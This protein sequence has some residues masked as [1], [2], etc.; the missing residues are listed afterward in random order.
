[1][2][3]REH[4]LWIAD[5]LRSEIRAERELFSWITGRCPGKLRARLWEACLRQAEKWR[6]GSIRI[7]ALE[8]SPCEVA[9]STEN[10]RERSPFIPQCPAVL[11][12][13]GEI[14]LPSPRIAVFNSRKPRTVR[15]DAE[16]LQ[17]LRYLLDALGKGKAV[18]STSTGTLTYDMVG[19]HAVSSGRLPVL[20]TPSSVLEPD[21]AVQNLY[22]DA[23]SAFPALSCMIET[24]SC[25]KG[26]R[27]QCRDRILAAFAHV[28]CVL[29][30]RRGGNLE[31]VL[32]NLHRASPRRLIVFQPGEKSPGNAG[33]HALVEEF[34][35]YAHVFSLR[36]PDASV[37]REASPRAERSSSHPKS[38]QPDPRL[39]LYHYTRSCPGPWPG[40]SYEQYLMKLLQGDP[41]AGHSALDTLARILREGRLRAASGMVRG[42]DA[43]VSWTSRTPS[44]IAALRKW[45]PALV[46]W[47]VEPCGVAV[48]RDVLRALGA[49]PAVYGRDDHFSKLPETER[50]R[51]QIGITR[52]AEWRHEREWRL[53]GD[54]SLDTAGAGNCFVFVRN[55]IEKR[56]LLAYIRTSL[57]V[58]TLDALI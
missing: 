19:V 42:R 55:E 47:T 48:K 37:N 36:S 32:Q 33:N 11:F 5:L 31:S 20:V 30:L 1:M 43:A 53:R 17:A 25:A 29:E 10:G 28:H 23:M 18:L 4:H 44:G 22:G 2:S 13:R 15:P 34:R 16:W 6:T 52:N 39:F 26:T 3:G 27:F 7:M 51:F 58:V 12:C 21:P 8:N 56:T 41:H 40:E 49:K 14:D 54:F 38:A 35:A 46:R 50:F 45:N 57:P 9:P 24:R